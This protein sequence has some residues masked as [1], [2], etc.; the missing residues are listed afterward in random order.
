MQNSKS[1]LVIIL[2]FLPIAI[3]SQTTYVP[4]WA[5]DNLFLNRLE[6]KAQTNNDLNLSTVK[7]Y[8]RKAYVAVADSFRTMLLNGSNPAKLTKID[9]YNL[10]RFQANNKEYSK[11]DLDSMPDWKR[12]KPWGKYFFPTKGNF[13][14]V[15]EKD[16]Y[17]SLNPV[18]NFN[19]GKE[20][21]FSDI[22][23][24]NSKGLMFRGLI[25]K[26]IGFD[27]FM[28]DNQE[29]GPV[30]FREF[31][32]SLKAVPGE[33]FYKTFKTN[34]VDYFDARGS[35]TW[36]VTKYI[37][38]QFGYDKQFIGNGYRSLF[39][40]DFSA[41]ALFLKFNTRIWK[42]NY[43]NLFM[44]LFPTKETASANNKVLTRK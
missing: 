33:A 11:F 42:I 41:P 14:E 26:K 35:V 25:A 38:M 4:L 34:G 40:S 12:K 32:D 20:T 6:I 22:L 23:Y 8:M 17:L 44:E 27:F 13:L 18:F 31:V 15:N 28:A 19:A 36:N 24:V 3:F 39:L 10:N 2:A 30:Q 43:T 7:P 21:N 1:L 37:N 29:R 5:K 9:Q 16:F